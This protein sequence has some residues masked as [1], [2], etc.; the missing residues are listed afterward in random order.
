M[1]YKVDG[2][3]VR[4]LTTSPNVKPPWIQDMKWML[5]VLNTPCT[6]VKPVEKKGA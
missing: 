6:E 4:L 5:Y 2:K 1:V 3:N